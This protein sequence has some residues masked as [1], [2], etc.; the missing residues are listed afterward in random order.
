MRANNIL[1]KSGRRKNFPKSKYMDNGYFEIKTSSVTTAFGIREVNVTLI[2]GKG[3][4]AL[5]NKI[6]DYFTADSKR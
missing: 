5:I 6:V 1:I 4:V 2:T 3:Q